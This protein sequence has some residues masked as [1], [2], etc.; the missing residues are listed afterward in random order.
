LQVVHGLSDLEGQ[1]EQAAYTA[2]WY[3][4]ASELSDMSSVYKLPALPSSHDAKAWQSL[5]SVSLPLSEQALA[6]AM[7]STTAVAG[8]ALSEQQL[9]QASEQLHWATL[10]LVH[11]AITKSQAHVAVRCRN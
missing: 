1:L 9:A 11:R 8:S 2:M 10:F 3:T 6:A 5:F 7:A 4:L